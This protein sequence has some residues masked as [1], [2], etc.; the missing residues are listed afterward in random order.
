M[1]AGEVTGREILLDVL[2]SEGVRHVFG[3][4][5]STE[6]P[7]VDALAGV[8][9]ISYVLALQE[10][11]AVGMADGYAQATGRPAFLNL[12]TSAGL[13]NAIGNLTNA[14]ANGTALV[15][16]AGQQ[17]ERQLAADPL[18][19]G[20]LTELAAP[21]SKWAH[22]VRSLGELG[23]LLRRAFADA[24]KAPPGPVFLS[25]RM[26][27]LERSGPAADVGAPPRSELALDATAGGLEELADL[28]TSV[29]VGRLGIVAGDEVAR[30]GAQG[31]LAA[32]AEAL[33]APV[34][35]APLHAN[36]VFDPTHPLW[37]GMLAP[38][39]AAIRSA[40]DAYDRVLLVGGQAF[41]VYPYTPGPTVPERVELLHLSPDPAQLGRAHPV[42]LGVAGAVAPSLDA[43]VPLVAARADA[44]A[45]AD[46]LAAATV[47]R[48]GELEQLESTASERY[49]PAPMHPMAAAHAL[50]RAVPP[51]TAVVD[52]AITTGVYVRGFHHRAVDDG[53]FFCKGGGLGWGMPAACGVSLG[54][55]RSPVL[56]AVGDG[57]AMYS[58]QALWTAAREH[59]PVVFAVVDNGQ[60]RILKDYLRD[61]G[62]VSATTGRFVAMDLA[63]AVDHVGLA[64]SMGVAATRID[65]TGDVGDA[66]RAALDAGEP[67]LLHLPI[68]A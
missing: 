43:L 51:G 4:P 17:D 37:A 66:V 9:D 3:N 48:R 42:R 44:G 61:M 16:T 65:S 27:L 36:A 21:T 2:R 23:T 38:A 58:P 20:P 54:R 29:P 53:Y 68:T 59:L 67:H 33:G 12:H 18:L 40:L 64:R 46:A 50:V 13:G 34:H 10:A 35:G 45:A 6:L 8:D 24:A 7:L 19:S 30:D 28:L 25:L 32:L 26:D 63:P 52:E 22:E 47:R 14:R 56:C 62:G 11:T 31:R 60:Y 49:G 39:A 57:S 1:A 15:V 5:G 41:L 55:D